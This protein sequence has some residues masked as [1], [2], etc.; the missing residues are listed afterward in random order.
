MLLADGKPARGNP[1]HTVYPFTT[2]RD[3]TTQTLFTTPSSTEH[4]DSL[5]YSQFYRLIKTPFNTSKAYVFQQ[6]ALENLVLDPGYVRSLQ[7]E[8]G[9]STFSEAVCKRAYLH[10]KRRA[11]VNLRDN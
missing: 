6:D 8:G 3:S 2:T 4:A 5:V 9:A 7:Q 10:M 11:H 1:K